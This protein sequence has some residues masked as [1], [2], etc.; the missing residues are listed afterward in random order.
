MEVGKDRGSL[1]YY[2]R[3]TVDP[4]TTQRLGDSIM[5]PDPFLIRQPKVHGQ[6]QDCQGRIMFTMHIS[7]RTHIRSLH[8]GLVH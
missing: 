1:A 6:S 3:V 8:D 5:L 2:Y 4:P 7:Q